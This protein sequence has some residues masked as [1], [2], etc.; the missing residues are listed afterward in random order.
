MKRFHK[1]WRPFARPASMIAF[2][3][4]VVLFVPAVVSAVPIVF[5]DQASFLAALGGATPTTYDFEVGSG[6]PAAGGTIGTFGGVNFAAQTE[7]Y[8]D[9]ASGTQGMT[10]AGGTFTTATVNFLG[11]AQRPNAIGMFGLDLTQFGPE[12]VRVSATFTSG[13]TRAFDI[14][15]APGA[16]DFTPTFLG[17][18]DRND[19]VQSLSILGT[20]VGGP[21]P[22]RAWLIDDLVR[23]FV[24]PDPKSVV[25]HLSTTTSDGRLVSWDAKYNLSLTSGQVIVRVNIRL[26]DLDGMPLA[27]LPTLS[28]PRS[29]NADGCG[30]SLTC[31]WEKGI[32]GIW[33]GHFNVLDPTLSQTYPLLFDVNFVSSGQDFNTR[34]DP[35]APCSSQM[36]RWCLDNPGG[37]SNDYQ[38]EVAAHEFGHQVGLYDEYTPFGAVDPAAL[39]GNI[40]SIPPAGQAFC[41]SL[42]A[43]LGP[44]KQRY[45]ESILANL[46]S[47]LGR[48]LSLAFAG[49]PPYPADAPLPDYGLHHGAPDDFGSPQQVPAPASVVFLLVGALAGLGYRALLRFRSGSAS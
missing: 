40:C 37:F 22:S 35:R 23:A 14:R 47:L 38:D 3:L 5:N 49:Q 42:M 20:E 34:V 36:S 16:P 6:F 24:T 15:L 28:A 8:P 9:T 4:A 32:E 39:L 33:S 29:S 18:I 11:L 25:T 26:V 41:T 31:I 30:N 21:P 48:N 46:E 45:Y 1:L 7:T 10:G 2:G 19:T 43:D 13:A 27:A 44:T 17:I 12:V